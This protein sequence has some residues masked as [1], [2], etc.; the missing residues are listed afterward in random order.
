MI[1][2]LLVGEPFFLNEDQTEHTIEFLFDSAEIDPEICIKLE[3]FADKMK[4][5]IGTQALTDEKS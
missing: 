2:K 3:L 1:S 5:L 4:K